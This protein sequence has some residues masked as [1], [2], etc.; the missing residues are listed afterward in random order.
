MFITQ[1]LSLGISSAVILLPQTLTQP[2]DFAIVFKR[3]GKQYFVRQ[4]SW[5]FASKQRHKRTVHAIIIVYGFS[6]QKFLYI[7]R[8]KGQSVARRKNAFEMK[9]ISQKKGL[10]QMLRMLQKRIPKAA[11]SVHMYNLKDIFQGCPP[12]RWN[13]FVWK[14]IDWNWSMMLSRWYWIILYVLNKRV[15]HHSFTENQFKKLKGILCV[16]YTWL[17]GS[18]TSQDLGYVR[19]NVL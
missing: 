14:R 15:L 8:S 12:Q 18:F 19:F 1:R 16:T 4:I 13:N 7:V 9:Q 2:N 17:H 3:F 6:F 10:E 5:F 11:L